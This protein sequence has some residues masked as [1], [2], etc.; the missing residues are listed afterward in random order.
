MA[1]ILLGL[2]FLLEQF[3]VRVAMALVGGLFLSVMGVGMLRSIKRT[4]FAASKNTRSSM[5]AGIVLSAGN[6]PIGGTR[7]PAIDV[8]LSPEKTVAP[9]YLTTEEHNA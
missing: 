8:V 3:Y 1:C 7:P 2:G 9:P 5:V 4:E 6:P